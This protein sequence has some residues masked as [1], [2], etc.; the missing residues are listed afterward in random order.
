VE[1]MAACIRENGGTIHTGTPV[2]KILVENGKTVGVRLA[3]GEEVKASIVLASGG[4]KE[5]F[6]KMV[7]RELL[8]KALIDQVESMQPM[9]SVLMVHLGIDMSP[10]EY[11]RNALCYYYGT[12]DIEEAV[13][14]CRRGEFTEGDEGFLIYVPSVHSPGMAPEGHHAV[15]IYTIAPNTLAKGNWQERR[16][17][18]ADKLVQKAERYMPGLRAHT[19]HRIIMT[20]DDF[21]TITHLSHHAFGGIA[22]VMGKSNP[23]HKT[24]VK[25]LFFIGAQS[26]SG[27]G[28]TGVMKGARTVVRSILQ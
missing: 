13:L 2:E 9:E 4:A 1:A 24:P 27:G 12:Y 17:D 3:G 22:P 15:T 18:L 26:E 21:K 6:C 8:P 16:E 14:S 5:L 25:G 23:S 7:G 20:P 28:V 10:A 11:Q 19:L